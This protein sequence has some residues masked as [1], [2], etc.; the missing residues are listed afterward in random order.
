MHTDTERLEWILN[1]IFESDFGEG[2]RFLVVLGINEKELEGP[3]EVPM[4]E[5]IRK[6][7]DRK[8]DA[9]PSSPIPQSEAK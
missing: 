7:I 9:I 3:G 5:L 8:L 4:G 6:A 2:T 1:T